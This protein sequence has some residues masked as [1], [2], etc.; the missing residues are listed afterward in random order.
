MRHAGRS[1][2]CGRATV[3]WAGR[4]GTAVIAA[5][6]VLWAGTL[7]TA[8]TPRILVTGDSWAQFSG[9]RWSRQ[10]RANGWGFKYS[11]VNTGIGGQTAALL[12][13]PNFL[14]TQIQLPLLKNPTIDMVHL[15]IGGNDFLGAWRSSS[16]PAQAQALYASVQANVQG[17]ISTIL[18]VRPNIQVVVSSYDYLNFTDTLANPANLL[19]WQQLGSPTPGQLNR[20][21]FGNQAAPDF[22]GTLGLEDYKAAA[23]T[24]NSRVRYISSEGLIQRA[25]WGLSSLDLPTPSAYMGDAIHL[26]DRGWDL[27][28]DNYFNNFFNG[29]LQTHRLT[30]SEVA[31]APEP[32]SWVL[33]IGGGALVGLAARR[34]R[35]G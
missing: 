15:T 11:A 23:A 12:N 6:V 20:A 3:G 28:I 19:L 4:T 35:R 29:W 18:A 30:G 32:A 25:A 31:V 9:S 7:A 1:G 16:T 13:T 33:A 2:C 17:I 24:G 10:F 21:L 34:R 22:G 27:W 14:A 5:W 8:A 26:N